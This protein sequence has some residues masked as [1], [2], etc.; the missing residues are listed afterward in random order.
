MKNGFTLK[1]R[2]RIFLTSLHIAVIRLVAF[3]RP[4]IIGCEFEAP[5]KVKTNYKK[6]V[7]IANNTIVGISEGIGILPQKSLDPDMFEILSNLYKKV[8]KKERTNKRTG[9]ESH[10]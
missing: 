3:N 7:Y 2:V 4:L 10:V 5:V 9:G 6:H 1:Q 8:G